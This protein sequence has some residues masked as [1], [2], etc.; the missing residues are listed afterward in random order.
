M[1]KKK[2]LPHFKSAEDEAKFWETHSAANYLDQLKEVDDLF[3]LSPS[4]IHRIKNH[5]KK[6]LISLRLAVWEIQAA[7]K[8]AKRKKI[9]YQTLLRQW[10]D[11][12]LK[13]Q[14][15]GTLYR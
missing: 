9:P 10:I 7:K 3:V 8:I 1:M 2:R 5:A 11:E 12:G 6:K 4:L 14:F 15:T 13:H